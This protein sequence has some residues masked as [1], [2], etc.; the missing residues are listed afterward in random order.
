M[1]HYEERLEEDLRRIRQRIGAMASRVSEA[2]K[3]AVHALQTGNHKLAA[4]TILS[5]HPINRTMREIDR[6]C[7]GFIAVHLPSA[8]HLRLLSSAIRA[9]IGLE[10]IGDYAVTIARVSEQLSAPPQGALARELD[11]I[12]NAAQLMLKQAI[13]A[14]DTLNPEMA[15]ATMIMEQEMESD[16]ETVYSELTD[17][18]D[19]ESVKE[20]LA[21][22][23]V[24]TH[25]KRVA[26]QA[27]NLCEETIFAVTGET[28]APKVYNILFIDE[29]NSGLSQMA[30][31]IARK[32]F[33]GSGSYSSGGRN[34]AS[35]LNEPMV[36]F[37]EERGFDL[38]AAR[39]KPLD[40][41][42]LELVDKHVV[43]SLQGPVKSYIAQMPFHTTAL[44]WEVGSLPDG[45]DNG[46]TTQRLEAS[47]REIAVQIRDLME[48]LR[49][50][51][52]P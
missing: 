49:G 31:A 24:L 23:A 2:V 13:N 6:L 18:P 41:T 20:L 11:R 4:A 28:K 14:F 52:A 8:G 37:L 43:V 3:D 34:P 1:S 9:N 27:K 44:E 42:H 22:Y 21:I 17:N 26:D 30:E 47:Y 32:T 7:H 19:R 10:R 51:N 12:A 50:E 35:A 16:L 36:R 40:L 29:D 45:A 33:P 38:S 48:T 39:P 46:Q 15:R 5:D 25:L